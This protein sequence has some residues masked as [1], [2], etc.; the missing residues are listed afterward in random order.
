MIKQINFGDESIIAS[1]ENIN[2]QKTVKNTT[3]FDLSIS[4]VFILIQTICSCLAGVYNEY[5]LKDKGSDVN[6]YIQN[7]FMYLDSIVCNIFVLMMQGNLSGA[8]QIESL[9]SIFRFN[10]ILIMINNAAI[11]IITSKL[12]RFVT[13]KFV[14]T[15]F[16]S[17]RFF[18]QIL[19]LNFKNIRKCI[20]V[21]VHSSVVLHHFC[22]SDTSQHRSGYCYCFICYILVLKESCG[23]R[24]NKNY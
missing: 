7:V 19:E 3:G 22:N 4:A 16:F 20:G 10:V 2:E 21:T 13:C 14:N 18:P 9:Q 5:L 1:T 17:R 15:I 12:D 8:F 23:E 11:G 24:S 6:I